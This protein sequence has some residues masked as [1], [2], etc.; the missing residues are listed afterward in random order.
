[1]NDDIK[2]NFKKTHHLSPTSIN[3][4]LLNFTKIGVRWH[5]TRGEKLAQELIMRE[6]EQNK[7]DDLHTEEFKYLRYK[8]ISSKLFLK[9][10]KSKEIYCE[11]LENTSNEIVEGSIVYVGTGTIGEFEELEAQG[12]DFSDKVVLGRT[13]T[14]FWM[15]AEA[16]RRKACGVITV[17]DPPENLI[18][19]CT[20]KL[21]HPPVEENIESYKGTIPGVL[22]SQNEGE[23]LLRLL[24]FGKVEVKLEHKADYSVKKSFNIVGET[25]GR[26]YPDETIVIGAH[27]DTQLEGGVWDNGTGIAGLLEFSKNFQKSNPKRTIQYVAFNCEE[28]GLWGS[29]NYVHSHQKDNFVYMCNL[30]AVST[31]FAS[32]NTVWVTPEIQDHVL[33]IATLLDW[34]V[35]CI[36]DLTKSIR[37][38]SDMCAFVEEEVPSTWIWETFVTAMHPYYH[39][40]KDLIEYIDIHK[41]VKTLETNKIVVENM[42]NLKDIPKSTSAR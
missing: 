9:S 10:P 37:E 1:M 39:T 26:E 13:A 42:A 19:R 4:Y 12:F 7:L 18:R 21:A 34:P 2:L 16:E 8:P 28:I 17:T 25:E 23:R 35:G 33:K 31:S 24:N 3:K 27:Y 40:K 15:Y 29:T 38:F 30:D 5:D 36:S 6:L 20:G 14:P 11:P 41:F 32:E 22:I